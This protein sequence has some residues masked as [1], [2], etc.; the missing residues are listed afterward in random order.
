MTFAALCEL[1]DSRG[2]IVA[3]ASANSG[4]TH[5]RDDPPAMLR[6]LAIYEDAESWKTHAPPLVA[7]RMD[8]PVLNLNE[9]ADMIGATLHAAGVF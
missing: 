6:T 2:W 4:C 8:D 9:A 1:A 5:Y 3:V 7:V